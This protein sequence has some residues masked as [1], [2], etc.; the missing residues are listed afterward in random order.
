MNVSLFMISRFVILNVCNRYCV[1]RGCKIRVN[2]S[3][4]ISGYHASVQ[5]RR[6]TNKHFCVSSC[7]LIHLTHFSVFHIPVVQC[8]RWHGYTNSHIP[9]P[10]RNCMT[11]RQALQDFPDTSQAWLIKT[12]KS[13]YCF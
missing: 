4:T 8:N 11:H 10:G 5:I 2:A 7:F 1:Q 6:N 13:S 12:I 3:I 9:A